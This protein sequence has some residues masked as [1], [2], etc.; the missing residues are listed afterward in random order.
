MKNVCDV[1]E[2][3]LH[4]VLSELPGG[5][6]VADAL[7]LV[8]KLVDLVM[9]QLEAMET[10][11]KE[12]GELKDKVI[13]FTLIYKDL[14]EIIAKNKNI[15]ACLIAAGESLKSSL[16]VCEKACSNIV[17]GFSGFFNAKSYLKELKNAQD[18]LSSAI[19]LLDNALKVATLA[20]LHNL[21]KEIQSGVDQVKDKIDN[22]EDGVYINS[23]NDEY[24][25]KPPV[26]PTVAQNECRRGI[27]VS[28]RDPDNENLGVTRYEVM[29]TVNAIEKKF[30]FPISKLKS[31]P[32]TVCFRE[33]FVTTDNLYVVKV[34]AVNGC[35]PSPWSD[36]CFFVYKK[37]LPDP[38]EITS[39]T[40]KVARVCRV[41]FKTS[42]ANYTLTKC[43]VKYTD[44]DVYN[45]AS[46]Q[47]QTVEFTNFNITPEG[48]CVL[49]VGPLAVMTL[50]H[51]EVALEN[52]HGRSS[53]SRPRAYTTKV[54]RPGKPIRL[55]LKPKGSTRIKCTW[56][57]PK[58][59]PWA[60]NHYRIK[61]M[62]IPKPNEKKRKNHGK[63]VMCP[64]LQSEDK[65]VEY[66]ITNLRPSTNHRVE[67]AA[68]NQIQRAG[69]AAV[70]RCETRK[71]G[72]GNGRHPSFDSKLAIS[73][74]QDNTG[75]SVTE[76]RSKWEEL[77]LKEEK[78]ADRDSECKVL[79]EL[80]QVSKKE[81]RCTREIMSEEDILDFE[82]DDDFEDLSD[83]NYKYAYADELT[84]YESDDDN[85]E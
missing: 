37:I 23:N 75:L 45:D 35:G 3:F 39:I 43:L 19:N 63:W 70:K 44:T 14:M 25:S 5:S 26:K 10:A 76:R 6:A 84:D 49:S 61:Y 62:V 71:P 33:P 81:A 7:G 60:T 55:V 34:R 66:T 2:K 77:Q 73:A 58:I 59:R 72:G 17:K 18:S 40:E 67:I 28:W 80:G 22:P 57:K 48:K 54:Y 24:L 16:R 52:S 21:Q 51:F 36:E 32:Y 42:E 65:T 47:W 50:Y 31:S 30:P 82:E 85:T 38:P 27:T 11:K 41:E 12:I 8:A 69:E 13:S 4:V 78:S 53:W 64:T 15:P 56:E 74:E 1:T 79:K 46:T 83:D 20:Q 9:E 68:V 29:L